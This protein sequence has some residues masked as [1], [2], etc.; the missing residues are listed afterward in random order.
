MQRA[1]IARPD[2][3]DTVAVADAIVMQ[4]I[5]DLLGHNLNLIPGSKGERVMLVI[6]AAYDLSGYNTES[7]NFQLQFSGITY[8]V[9]L[10]SEGTRELPQR[11]D[12]L[13]YAI[14]GGSPQP[15]RSLQDSDHIFVV[16]T[17]EWP[18]GWS[19]I[20]DNQGNMLVVVAGPDEQEP[21]DDELLQL[22]VG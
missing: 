3:F 16:V 11:T 10:N 7:P 5:E 14:F 12:P 20:I 9:W 21:E 17:Y 22:V 13:R 8:N 15:D 2:G 1:W 4:S 18:N 6:K 19:P